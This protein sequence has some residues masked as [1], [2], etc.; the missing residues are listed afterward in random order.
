LRWYGSKNNLNLQQKNL[1]MS[2]APGEYTG[3]GFLYN[4]WSRK[5][6][7]GFGDVR[8]VLRDLWSR[9][10]GWLRGLK[11]SRFADYHPPTD[12]H[13]LIAQDAE[14]IEAPLGQTG[15]NESQNSKDTANALQSRNATEPVERLQAGFDKLVEK[16]QGINEHLD[17]QVVQRE[18]LMNRLDKLLNFMEAFPTIAENQKQLTD[19]L[20]EQ[21]KT[22]VTKNQ[23]FIDVIEKIPAETAKQ[24]HALVD[25]NYQLGAAADADAQM[26]ESLNRF[27]QTLDKVNQSTVSQTGCIT[28]MSKTFAS[29]ERYLKY[30]ISSQNKRI[31][32]I[33]T[34]AITVCVLVILILTAIII[35]VRQ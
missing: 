30:I 2:I 32:W 34:T 8:M 21:L 17:H 4:N 6:I 14:F 24:T 20:F 12:S 22:T 35:S 16:L 29:S 31:F 33:L 18:D 5:S 25:I 10:S 23:Q 27:N 3:G 26:A 13:G 28:Q 7:S 1:L 15:R 11:F 9:I 19:Q